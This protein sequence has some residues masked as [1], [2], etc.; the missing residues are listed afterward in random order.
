MG[1]RFSLLMPGFFEDDA[2]S[3]FYEI[4]YEVLKIEKHLSRFLEN[5]P[6]SRLNQSSSKTWLNIDSDILWDS[7]KLCSYYFTLTEGAFDITL[8]PVIKLWKKSVSMPSDNEI[9]QGLKISGM[10]K[11]EFNDDSRMI[12]L[13]IMGMEVDFGG[14][15][16]GYALERVRRIFSNYNVTNA[17][18]SF[19]ESSILTFGH[20]P[21]GDYWPMGIQNP[22]L[23]SE[24][25]HV[26]RMRNNSLTTSGN[27]KA[28]DDGTIKLNYHIISPFT[29]YPVKK[30]STVSVMNNLP[31]EGEVLSTSF[32][33]L[34]DDKKDRVKERFNQGTIV[35]VVYDDEFKYSKNII[36]L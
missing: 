10:D 31:V 11:V 16:K 24:N 8:A 28:N 4:R 19:G 36:A 5:S 9:K 33:V 27:V 3:L 23:K 18:V 7:L 25:V 22:F 12:R 6:V 15:A 14:F 29:G 30:H 1:T 20:H 17:V 21:A 2:E 34:A 26:F 13:G 32:M 35:E